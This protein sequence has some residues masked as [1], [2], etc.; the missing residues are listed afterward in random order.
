MKNELIV[1]EE[2]ELYSKEFEVEDYN[3]IMIDEDDV[4]LNSE[5]GIECEI[6]IR[7]TATPARGKIFKRELDRILVVFDE[8]QKSVTPGQSAVFY[9]G[10]IV[11][12][13]GK[14]K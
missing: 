1:G 3:L 4:R 13:G 8:P 9:D 10:D 14:I 11:L 6:K 7:Y 2:S 12:G 5:E